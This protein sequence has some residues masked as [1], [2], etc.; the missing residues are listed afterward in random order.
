MKKVYTPPAI[1]KKKEKELQR[2]LKAGE[3]TMSQ[4]LHGIN[5]AF[6]TKL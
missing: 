1:D 2:Q 4:Y 5:L 3:I 6:K